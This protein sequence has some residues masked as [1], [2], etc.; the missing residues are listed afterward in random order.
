MNVSEII[1][2][3][4]TLTHTTSTQ[5]SDAVGLQ[6]LNIVY[7]D[8]ENSIVTGIN[9]N[10]FWDTFTTDTVE[11]QNEYVLP[12]ASATVNGIR[13]IIDWRIYWTQ[14]QADD[15]NYS[16]L[17]SDSTNNYS[18]GLDYLEENQPTNNAFF[19]LREGSVFIYPTP[20]NAITNGL[21]MQA[22]IALK[23]LDWADEEV[24]VYPNQSTLRQFHHV[25]AVWMKQYIYS[26]QREFWEKDNAI[27]EYSIAK[28]WMLNFLE[29]R[30][31]AP[32]EWYLPAWTNLMN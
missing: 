14:E 16:K 22:I 19:E 21:K 23:D 32:V 2:L 30:T 18:E 7:H 17:S 10:F 3:A 8:L 11:D 20:E 27:Q 29:D 4:R 5:V 6:Y 28:D 31:N 24:D 1:W 25:L 12:V 13:K 26:Q 9:E 15:S